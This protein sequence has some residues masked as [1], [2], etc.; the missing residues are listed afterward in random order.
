MREADPA[1]ARAISL[2]AAD[3][4]PLRRW[5]IDQDSA[6]QQG[7]RLRHP[8]NRQQQAD[9]GAADRE[10]G[11]NRHLFRPFLTVNTGSS[12]LNMIMLNTTVY[13]LTARTEGPLTKRTWTALR[14]TT[15]TNLL[16]RWARPAKPKTSAM[17]VMWQTPSA[18]LTSPLEIWTK[19]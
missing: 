7:I 1:L 11:R 8:A 5:L 18:A 4:Q 16:K 12:R 15:S 3:D 9:P 13:A 19:P 2:A 17:P 6:G 14:K 10:L